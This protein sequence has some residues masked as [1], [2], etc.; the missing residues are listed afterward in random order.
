MIRTYL[1][2]VRG[3]PCYCNGV[4]RAANESL[5]DFYQRIEMSVYWL[6]CLVPPHVITSI[7]GMHRDLDKSRL[8]L[9][10]IHYMYRYTLND[11]GDLQRKMYILKSNT[12]VNV[13]VIIL[14]ASYVFSYQDGI[15]LIS[16]EFFTQLQWTCVEDVL[17]SWVVYGNPKWCK[18]CKNIH[19]KAIPKMNHLSSSLCIISELILFYER[20]SSG[21]ISLIIDI[22]FILWCFSRYFYKSNWDTLIAFLTAIHNARIAITAGCQQSLESFIYRLVKRAH[23][24]L[25]C[26]TLII[27]VN[28]IPR[29]Q[30][31]PDNCVYCSSKKCKVFNQLTPNKHEGKIHL[32]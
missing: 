27:I 24:S 18:A 22:K 23:N 32:S 17:K 26:A 15:K 13:C 11:R 4:M 14:I 5:H 12:Y 28:L 2:H 20:N 1:L 16:E 29:L 8:R 3:Q 10:L 9:L 7:I 19:Y 31:Y 25:D 21:Q 30:H 6:D